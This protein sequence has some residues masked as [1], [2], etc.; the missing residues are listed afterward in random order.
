M[1]ETTTTAHVRTATTSTQSVETD[2]PSVNTKPR[3]CPECGSKL[4]EDEARGETACTACGLVVE[5]CEIDHG[6][7][8]R[9]FNNE[10]RQN[11]KRTGAPRTELRHDRGL[12]TKI[13]SKTDGQGNQLSSQNRKKMWR[14]RKRNRHAKN[15][16]KDRTL[17]HAIGEIKRMGSALGIPDSPQETAAVIFRRAHEEGLLHGRSIEG[18]ATASLYTGSRMAG[19]P[20]TLDE[21]V[22]TSRVDQDRVWS[23]YKYIL[24][25]LSLEVPPANPMDYIVPLADSVDVSNSVEQE[26][27]ELLEAAK[28]EN[29]ISGNSPSGL[30]AGAIY[31]VSRETDEQ[32]TQREL[33]EGADVSVVTVRNQYR[34]L[35]ELL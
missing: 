23:A 5:E 16:H 19:I 29:Y 31:A 33:S 21:I 25:E 2:T 17:R 14:L 1:S 6:P 30:A 34:K 8:W 20:K 26:A 3:T 28:S 7:E 15:D 32:V 35:E 27:R 10:Q 9:S 18:V 13:G 24:Q 22:T 4:R 11:R 12:S